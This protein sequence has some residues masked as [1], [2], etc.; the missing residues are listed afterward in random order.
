M[1]SLAAGEELRASVSF[2]QILNSQIEFSSNLFVNICVNSKQY[3]PLS[4]EQICDKIKVFKWCF[5][6]ITHI[7]MKHFRGR[8]NIIGRC[9]GPTTCD[10]AN[11]ICYWPPIL[12]S[13]S[14]S[15]LAS[16]CWAAPVW[17]LSASPRSLKTKV[18]T[19][20]L[21]QKHHTVKLKTVGSDNALNLTDVVK[22][23]G[24]QIDL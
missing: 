10:R 6:N 4:P 13:I 7:H 11:H 9:I 18:S 14:Q 12:V 1:A 16:P 3:L 24:S 5:L 22:W 15:E 20:H 23:N 17:P 2:S 8:T 21:G 19:S